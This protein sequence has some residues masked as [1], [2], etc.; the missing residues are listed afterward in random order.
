VTISVEIAYEDESNFEVTI[1]DTG[2]GELYPAT[3]KMIK[4]R[5]SL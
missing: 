1:T 2:F 4:K 5:V 3:G